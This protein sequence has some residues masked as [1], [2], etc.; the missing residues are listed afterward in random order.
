MTLPATYQ[1]ACAVE[2]SVCTNTSG[3]LPKALNRPLRLPVLRSGQRCPTTSGAE[4]TTRY[5]SGVALG[6]GPVRPILSTR[7]DVRHG[8]AD[9]DPAG[10]PRWREFKTLWFSM[11]TY[12]GPFVIRA[13]SLDGSGPIRLGGSG[14]L[15]ATG[16]A[17]VV[18][19]GPTLNGGGGYR[20]APSGT[21]AKRAGC[22]GYQVD[23][24]TFSEVI[25]V[26]AVLLGQRGAGSAAA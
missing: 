2:S 18:P 23:G 10:V 20:T 5:L 22:Y 21:W 12:Q 13:R 7:G 24:L 9:L 19:P 17:I 16:M 3:R 6:T 14:G 11:P 25:V 8:I 1:Q 4:V 26:H 15:P